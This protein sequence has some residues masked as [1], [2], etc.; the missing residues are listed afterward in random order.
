MGK[1]AIY[2]LTPEEQQSIEGWVEDI[3]PLVERHPELGTVDLAVEGGVGTGITMPHIA[4]CLFP[5]ALYIGMDIA[6]SLMRIN[7]RQRGTIDEEL[8]RKAQA[9][10]EH[11]SLTMQGAMIYGNCFDNGL[12][13]DIMKKSGT[14]T[15]ILM[16]Y[17]A[18]NALL[19][20]KMNPWDR[21]DASDMTT[22]DTMVAPDSPYK[23]QL[24]IGTDWDDNEE[25]SVSSQYYYLEEAAK[26]AGCTTERLDSGLLI[27]GPSR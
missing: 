8:L 9:A 12:I 24:H 14:Q 27:L 4:R 19:D 23:A 26:N 7:P 25:T 3:L 10:S 17:Y 16:S 15:P 21:K 13:R 6:K 2:Y 5:N 20:R 18:L 1:E 22:I 11:P